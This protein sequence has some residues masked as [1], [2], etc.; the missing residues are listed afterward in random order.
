MRIQDST[1][2]LSRQGNLYTVRYVHRV[3]ATSETRSSERILNKSL[4]LFASRGYEATSVREICEAAGI[5]KPTLYHFYGSKE[6][7]YRA[8]VG[9]TLESF[10]SAVATEL[11]EPVSAEVRLRAVARTCFDFAARQKRMMR[12]IMARYLP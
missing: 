6:G 8:L 3:V 11:E 10:R 7:V 5:T 1:P 9:D 2:S 4:E 12:L